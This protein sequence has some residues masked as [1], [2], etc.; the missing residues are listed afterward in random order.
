MRSN[1]YH[2]FM[3]KLELQNELNLQVNIFFWAFD[4]TSLQEIFL[5]ILAIFVSYFAFIYSV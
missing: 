1:K 2:M 3:F 5:K 4:M